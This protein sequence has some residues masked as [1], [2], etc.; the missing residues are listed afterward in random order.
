M[1]Y[2]KMPP[3]A[4]TK[5]TLQEAFEWWS[6][7][8]EE[9]RAQVQDKDD[10]VGY[11]LRINRGVTAE[12]KKEG[13]TKAAKESFSSELKGL[14]K[15]LDTF[16]GYEGKEAPQQRPAQV[17]VQTPVVAHAF[18]E[19][20]PVLQKKHIFE[21]A[22]QMQFP[23]MSKPLIPARAENVAAAAA[24]GSGAAIVATSTTSALATT[25]SAQGQ[26]FK[27][28]AKSKSSVAKAKE[29]LNLSSDEEAL[30]ALIALGGAKIKGLI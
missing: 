20:S 28:D 25:S 24:A 4:Y 15:N 18:A 16:E 22:A 30:R 27:L 21:P 17:S 6:E 26:F 23:E 9:F 3:Q 29:L 19:S 10:L 5:E 11:Y 7:Q 1:P 8:P 13:F 14:V 12:P 2:G